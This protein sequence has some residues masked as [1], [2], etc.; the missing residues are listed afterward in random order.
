MGSLQKMF[1][2]LFILFFSIN[3]CFAS[4]SLINSKSKVDWTK[5]IFFSTINLDLDKAGISMPA[6]KM[7]ALRQIESELPD[8]IKDPILTLNID[9]DTQLGDIVLKDKI[10]LENI[11]EI[12]GRSK[13][14][15]GIFSAKDSVLEVENSIDTKELSSLLIEHKVPYKNSKPVDSVA[16]RPYSGIIIDARGNLEVH[17]EF[18]SDRANPCFFPVIW[19]EN[20]NLIY[21]KNMG[22]PEIESKKGMVHYDF[23][24]DISKY[25]D[26]IGIDPLYI[27]AR[28]VYG[29]FR[30]DPIISR[31]DA[32]KIL[33]V[34]ENLELL[35]EGKVVVLLD[36]DKL[37]YDVG[38]PE[39]NEEYYA[40]IRDLKSYL[41][42]NDEE[43]VIQDTVRGIQLLYDLKFIADSSEL[44]P[45]EYE[46][47]KKLA[48]IL[49]EINSENS[50]TILVEG[51]TADVNKPDGQM[52]LSIER[53][54][55]IIDELVKNGLDKDIFSYRGYGGTQPV[56]TNETETGRAQNRRVIIT[57]RP[58]ATY[59]QRK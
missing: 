7:S 3:Y 42:D 43:P 55:T 58:K 11:S 57:A 51:H 24:N 9:S 44:L 46:K 32:L 38:V 4:E 12:A 20:M 49:K 53:T 19:D 2:V 6:G 18:I 31:K 34:K 50:Y 29:R 30:T 52:K 27:S 10:S 59:I 33:C 25:K 40:A 37:I 5:N 39:K 1:K 22:S 17:G 14:S 41:Q 54:Q 23:D 21:E 35:K 26:R 36:K 47:V 28:K 8:L 16:S 56:A 13:K 15:A 45:S 48:D